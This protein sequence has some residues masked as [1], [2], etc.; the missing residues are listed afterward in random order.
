LARGGAVLVLCP[1]IGLTPQLVERFER[2]FDAAI[3]ALHSGLTDVQ[4]ARERR[5]AHRDRHALR[6]VHAAA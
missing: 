6:G 5:G 1:E 3:A 4:R 2:R